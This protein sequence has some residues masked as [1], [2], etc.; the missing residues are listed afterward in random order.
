MAD[1]RFIC[2]SEA[3]RDARGEDGYERIHL[4]AY[5]ETKYSYEPHPDYR[6]GE[7][8]YR[9]RARLDQMVD[10]LRACTG[11]HDPLRLSEQALHGLRRWAYAPRPE[12]K[13]AYEQWVSRPGSRSGPG[14]FDAPECVDPQTGKVK[15]GYWDFELEMVRDALRLRRALE[16]GG[17]ISYGFAVDGASP[18]SWARSTRRRGRRSAWRA[19]K[20]ANSTSA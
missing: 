3:L 8:Y 4:H 7:A 13:K 10:L 11:V 9:A 20:P 15:E 1:N 18:S 2:A 5:G 14:R 17:T 16:R 12:V 19:T 6:R